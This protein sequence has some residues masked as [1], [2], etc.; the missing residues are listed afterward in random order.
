MVKFFLDTAYLVATH[1]PSD[2]MRKDGV[3]LQK[4]LE[5]FRWLRPSRDLYL[6]DL[7]LVE[8]L[9]M[10]SGQVGYRGANEARRWITNNCIVART[11]LR[12]VG[13]A[14]EQIS[15]RYG[16][17]GARPLGVVDAI[18][19]HHMRRNGVGIILSSDEGFDAV[20]GLSRV[21]ADRMY[22]LDAL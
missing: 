20:A 12:D 17:S 14:F 7:V 21:W 13:D 8:T 15:S 18:S 2:P 10:L 3:R 5:G 22:A 19:V 9:Q 11:S 6:S 16:Q 4:R 1:S